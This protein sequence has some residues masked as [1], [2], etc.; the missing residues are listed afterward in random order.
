MG[1]ACN[2]SFFTKT[3]DEARNLIDS[4]ALYKNRCASH[5]SF[6]NSQPEIVANAYRRPLSAICSG[7]EVGSYLI[8]MKARNLVDGE[9]VAP[10]EGASHKSCC[11]S[12]PEIATNAHRRLVT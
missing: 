3:S 9:V 5:R 7:F 12:Q 2:L 6:G 11:N 8:K 10:P 1:E 4:D